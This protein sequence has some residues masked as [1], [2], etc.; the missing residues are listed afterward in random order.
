ME[1]MKDSHMASEYARCE[2]GVLTVGYP[3]RC[4]L[5]VDKTAPSSPV[6]K[7]ETK[8]THFIGQGDKNEIF[9]DDPEAH[10]ANI[11]QTA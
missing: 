4:P 6:L 1:G 9:A 7:S 11:S 5:L 8:N 3:G 2:L 10:Q